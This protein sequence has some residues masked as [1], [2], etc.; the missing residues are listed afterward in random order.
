MRPL[1]WLFVVALVL[2]SFVIWLHRLKTHK[3]Y[4]WMALV[5]GMGLAA[6]I[7]G[8]VFLC[9]VSAARWR[10]T[11]HTISGLAALL[12]M[13]GHFV[14][15]IRATRAGGKDEEHF[16]RFSVWAWL[17]WLVAFVSGIPRQ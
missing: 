11:L 7:S 10:W 17:I 5:F 9:V 12:I 2:Y 3:L 1:E 16:T 15:A 6:D 8:T 14:W 4:T 13:F